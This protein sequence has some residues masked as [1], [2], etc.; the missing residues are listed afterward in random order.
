MAAL[1]ISDD[2]ILSAEDASARLSISTR[3]L[4]RLAHRYVGLPPVAMI[5]R[6]RLQEAAQRVRVDAQS[7]L[8]RIA[9]EFGYADHAHLTNDFRGVLGMTPRDYRSG[10]AEPEVSGARRAAAASDTP[11]R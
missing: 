5:R 6:R 7:G 3:T 10:A 9:A 1:L 2:A 8:A 11:R 4:Q